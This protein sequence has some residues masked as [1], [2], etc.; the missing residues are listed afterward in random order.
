MRVKTA[1]ADSDNAVHWIEAGSMG[2]YE[3]QVQPNSSCMLP[4]SCSVM[5]RDIANEQDRRIW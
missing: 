4:V 1:F 5:E 3:D 2:W